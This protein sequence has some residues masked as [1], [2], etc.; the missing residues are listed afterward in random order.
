MIE[1][2]FLLVWGVTVWAL[3][4]ERK[5]RIHYENAVAAVST[6]VARATQLNV[7]AVVEASIKPFVEAAKGLDT[8]GQQKRMQVL[9]EFLKVH[10]GTAF[11]VAEAAIEKVL[12][13]GR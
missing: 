10:P 12:L 8:S 5:A 2:T 11:D 9:L 13:D 6:V 7:P 1:L 4:A 3:W